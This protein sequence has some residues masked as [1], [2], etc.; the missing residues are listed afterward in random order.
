MLNAYK[1]ILSQRI[2]L[3][4]DVYLY[5][6]DLIEPKEIV[7][8]AGQYLTLKISTD[9]GPL[10][11]LY[12]I[13]SAN[14][15]KNNFNLIIQIFPG[16][17]ASTFFSNL[18]IQDEVIFYGPSGKF[19]VKENNRPKIFLATGTG[20]APIKSIL[21]SEQQLL[22]ANFYLFWGVKTLKDAYLVEE[23]KK[24][25][26]KICLSREENLDAIS[27]TD[28][29]YFDLGYVNLSLEKQLN[30]NRMPITDYD[31]YLCGGKEIVE[32]LRSFLI[33]KGILTSNIF[34][35]KF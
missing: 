18:N 28:R 29:P 10:S 31:F 32:S 5:R 34:F 14:S 8:T 20:I 30:N 6:F 3:T 27:E 23:I 9:R 2:Q 13:A 24:F 12:S 19:S 17:L 33:N 25:N 15:E 35:E 16:G 22:K 1:T 4:A 26:P 21:I 7:F 11:R